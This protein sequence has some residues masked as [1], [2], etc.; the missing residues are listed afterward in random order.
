MK[1]EKSYYNKKA[2]IVKI[3]DVCYIFEENINILKKIIPKMVR[4]TIT[5]RKIILEIG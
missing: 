1:K 4:K 3:I 2:F 5:I